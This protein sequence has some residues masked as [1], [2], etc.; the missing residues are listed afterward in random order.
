MAAS[1]EARIF[2]TKGHKEHLRGRYRNTK[3]FLWVF[4]RVRAVRA[5]TGCG[6]QSRAPR[7][8]AA[9][10]AGRRGG[11]TIAP[12][13]H[14]SREVRVATG[15]VRCAPRG[16]RCQAAHRVEA[17]RRDGDIA[18]Y[19]NGARVVVRTTGCGGRGSDGDMRNRVAFF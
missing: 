1:H 17:R 16:E 2:N 7:R 14:A 11:R 13:R 18:P 9:A 10:R 19:R 12:Y 6:W 3:I 5:A 4:D 15:Y 8:G